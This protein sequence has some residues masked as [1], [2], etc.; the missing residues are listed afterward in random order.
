MPDYTNYIPLRGLVGDFIEEHEL[1]HLQSNDCKFK[2]FVNYCIVSRYVS[3]GFD[4]T[5]V[6]T[7]QRRNV[8]GIDGIAIVVNE[9]LVT[10]TEQISQIDNLFEEN[11]IRLDIGFIFIRAKNTDR[12]D[13]ASMENFS[14]AVKR[15]FNTGPSGKMSPPIEE[16][17]KGLMQ[18]IF[19]RVRSVDPVLTRCD[20]RCDMYYVIPGEQQGNG[21]LKKVEEKAISS[22]RDLRIAGRNLPNYKFSEIRFRPIGLE[23]LRQFYRTLKKRVVKNIK[24]T[25]CA[26][27]PRLADVKAAQTGILSCRE[28]LDFITDE[29]GLIQRNLF[30]ENVRDYKGDKNSVNRRIADTIK[31]QS[32]QDKFVLQNNGVTIVAKSIEQIGKEF[33][34][35]DYKIVNGCQT[36][37]VLYLNREHLKNND[38]IYLTVKIIATGNQEISRLIVEGTNNQTPLPETGIVDRVIERKGAPFGFIRRPRGQQD[39]YVALNKMEPSVRFRFKKGQ[40]VKFIV[41]RTPSG[42]EARRVK[43]L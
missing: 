13:T 28:F 35:T 31:T 17:L 12:F 25:E 32:K 22:I 33:T 21:N 43:V 38:N 30:N 39:V 1:E 18:Y 20:T 26:P 7:G 10:S 42:L 9:R 27:L 16:D 36:S 19:E 24:F 29:E 11:P 23:S 37:H 41:G 6:S 40:K 8:G 5:D 15:F 4:S 34:L 14:T 2:H 3:D